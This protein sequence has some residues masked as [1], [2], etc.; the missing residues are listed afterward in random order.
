[1]KLS[2]KNT[3]NKRRTRSIRFRPM[4]VMHRPEPYTE[5]EMA[6]AWYSRDELK[7][8][9]FKLKKTIVL[10]LA[11]SPKANSSRYCTRGLE[12]LTPSGQD[13]KQQ[14]R[15]A[16]FDTVLDEQEF[17][18]EVGIP[19]PNLLA[20]LYFESTAYSQYLA[21]VQGARDAKAAES[22]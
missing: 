20:D 10:M 14:R 1:M 19:D 6:A 9:Q 4:V 13:T 15:R 18:Q 12:S 21:E 16:A 8:L 7:K 11:E 3:N 17:Q 5:E 22:Q 2:P